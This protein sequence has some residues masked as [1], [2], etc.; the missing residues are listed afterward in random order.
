MAVPVLRNRGPRPGDAAARLVD[1]AVRGAMNSAPG[2]GSAALLS[3]ERLLSAIS[4]HL[5]TGSGPVLVGLAQELGEL[6]VALLATGLDPVRASARPDEMDLRRRITTVVE[7][8]D[9]WRVRHLPHRTGARTHTHSLGQTMDQVA[10]RYA[11]ARWSVRH[12]VNRRLRRTAWFHLGQA[13]EGYA[14]LVADIRAGHVELPVG[15]GGFR[16]AAPIRPS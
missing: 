8:I 9:T 7:D 3:P 12:S 10:A 5:D 1:P 14:H 11:D 16:T 15:W 4:G 2:G 13:R 6:R